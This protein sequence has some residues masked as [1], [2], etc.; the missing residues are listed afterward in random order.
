VI[1][2]IIIAGRLA[3][4]AGA[5]VLF[6]SSAFYLYSPVADL[7][8]SFAQG[9]RLLLAIAAA[10]LAIASLAAIAWQSAYF[11][12]SISEGLSPENLT[13]VATQM[14]LG[15]AALVRAA[16]AAVAM[17]MLIVM[18]PGPAS[19][20]V[21]ASFGAVATVSLAWMGH[22]GAGEGDTG[23]LLLASDM[24]HLLAAAGWLGALAGFV[25][26]LFLEPTDGAVSRA[27]YLAL[28]R[29]SRLGS[30]LVAALVGTGIVNTLTIVG[31]EAV[32]AI[33]VSEYGR[34]L[35]LKLLLFAAMI[36]FAAINRF[37]LTPALAGELDRAWA[38]GFALR[39]LRRSVVL[40]T[41]AGATVLMLVA[42]LGT[43]SPNLA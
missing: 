18:R 5:A 38:S 40:E 37:R 12:G 33:W 21:A 15:K 19:W 9:A 25:H 17:A 41:I 43:L 39:K 32:T 31:P 10:V 24:I 6:G 36:G 27:H 14:T 34:V 29:F 8:R 1:E 20:A 42:W 16:S 23:L 26:L 30:L 7:P 22:A 13:A 3:Q 4:Y 28:H 11:A 35:M 2:E